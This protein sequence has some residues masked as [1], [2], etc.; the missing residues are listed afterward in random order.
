MTRLLLSGHFKTKRS[1]SWT[2]GY[3][4]DSKEDDWFFRKTG[5]LVIRTTRQ[6]GGDEN[7]E[8]YSMVKVMNGYHPW[9]MERTPILDF[10][11][12]LADG[13]IWTGY[14]PKARIHAS[15][16][17][18]GDELSEDEKFS[19]YDNQ[20]AS[21]VV[22]TPVLSEKEGKVLHLGVSGRTGNVD[23][24]TLRIRSKPEMN[25]APYFV[26]TGKIPAGH[27]TGA[28]FEAFYRTGPWL[29]GTEH[30]WQTVDAASGESPTFNGGHFVVTRL[31]SAETRGYNAPGGFFNAVSPKKTITERGPGAI[32]TVLNFSYI[33]LNSGSFQGGKM[34]RLTP[35]LNWYASDNV[36]FELAY[37]YAVL[38]RFGLEG[39]SQFLQFRIQTYL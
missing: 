39:T 23:N 15:L 8:G 4:Y 22:W 25:L 30:D 34:W 18:F 28:G 17:I 31:F 1:I 11:P 7:K 2:V 26:D 3:M 20:V 5:V 24:D 14:F 27:A 32:E 6:C 33:N 35:M 38:D 10:V 29:F 19:T 16:G 37:G 21:R 9:G 13:V 36:R 12:I